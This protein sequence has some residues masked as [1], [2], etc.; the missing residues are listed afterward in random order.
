MPRRRTHQRP[1]VVQFVKQILARN[2]VY[3]DTETTGI[4]GRAEIVEI[5]VLDSDGSALLDT[6]VKPKGRIP[7]RAWEV[8]GIDD[9]MVAEAP[10]LDAIWPQLDALLQSRPLVIYNQAFDLRLLAQSAKRHGIFP[11][12]PEEVYCA[13]L[14]YAEYYG[15]WD[16]E[17][18]GYTWQR[19]QEALT[20]CKLE[21]P[22]Q[23]QPH[24]AAADCWATRMIMEYMAARAKA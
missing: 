17:R 24:R 6:L 20:Q 8:H 16:A 3:L 19:L 14:I 2:P 9:D 10:G 22:P 15:A 13:M 12:Q 18:E 5:A 23:L 1:K 21:L 7:Y 4:D 11:R